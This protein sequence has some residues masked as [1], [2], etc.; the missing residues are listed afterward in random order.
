[1]RRSSVK[2]DVRI[3]RDFL[4]PIVDGP[5]ALVFQLIIKNGVRVLT[6]EN[7]IDWARF[8]ISLLHRTPAQMK[9]IRNDGAKTLALELKDK[10]EE[11]LVLHGKN[12]E[13]TLREYAEK[14]V[15]PD[16]LDD[17]GA[18]V[19]PALVTK[20]E[21]NL[22]LLNSI[23]MTRILKQS[24]NNFLVGDKPLICNGSFKTSFVI[25]LLLT[26]KIV[27]LLLILKKQ[28]KIYMV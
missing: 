5:A 2:P 17:M 12:T 1:M 15:N 8:I 10:P 28:S 16:I 4:G 3:E 7:Q 14:N 27:F 20:P 9:S 6:L 23:W 21:L 11:Y 19:L 13:K 18:R 24:Q 26:P 22:P 25:C